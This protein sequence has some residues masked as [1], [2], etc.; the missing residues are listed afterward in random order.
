MTGAAGPAGLV[1]ARLLQHNSIPCTV[2]EKERDHHA[3]AQGGSLDLYENFAVIVA[4]ETVLGAIERCS[5]VRFVVYGTSKTNFL[6]A[7]FDRA[8]GPSSGS[9]RSNS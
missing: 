8:G 6:A 3:R 9:T 2:Y 7:K 4:I 1:L 5:M